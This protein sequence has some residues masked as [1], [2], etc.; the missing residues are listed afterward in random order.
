MPRTITSRADANDASG[1]WLFTATYSNY[2]K[3]NVSSRI[4]TDVDK[5]PP[6]R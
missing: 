3:L 1:T 4:I 5:N 2:H 6:P